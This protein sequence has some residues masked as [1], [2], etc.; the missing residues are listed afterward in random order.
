MLVSTEWTLGTMSFLFSL[1]EGHWE[2]A[3]WICVF[4]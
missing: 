1:P 3:E 4:I 2:V